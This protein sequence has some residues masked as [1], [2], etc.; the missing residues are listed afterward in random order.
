MEVSTVM[1]VRYPGV[2]GLILEVLEVVEVAVVVVETVA[3]NLLS[4]K[5]LAP[6]F[7]SSVG[8]SNA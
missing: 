7:L 5:F 3:P 2:P 4:C 8:F 1:V 6:S